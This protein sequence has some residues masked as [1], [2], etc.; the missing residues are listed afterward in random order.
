MIDEFEIMA[1]EAEDFSEMIYTLNFAPAE[2]I[3][4][5]INNKYDVIVAESI[6]YIILNK[7][8][9]EF[10]QDLIDIAGKPITYLIAGR[11]RLCAALCNSDELRVLLSQV[12]IVRDSYYEVWQDAALF[13][14]T[15]QSSYYEELL[16]TIHCQ[17]K[18]ISSLANT[19]IELLRS[20]SLDHE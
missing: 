20:E 16:N 5:A 8:V 9:K 13:L 18:T 19:L 1:Q 7:R 10:I 12:D 4:A 6:D 15:G 14:E 17:D 2:L 11:L 3:V